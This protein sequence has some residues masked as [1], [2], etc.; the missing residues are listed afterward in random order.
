MSVNGERTVFW[1]MQIIMQ[2]L[3]QFF[4]RRMQ[5]PQERTGKFYWC[6]LGYFNPG[7]QSS[8]K[9]WG[10]FCPIR[11]QCTVMCVFEAKGNLSDDVLTVTQSKSSGTKLRVILT[12]YKVKKAGYFLRRSAWYTL[13]GREAAQTCIEKFK[14]FLFCHKIW[15]FFHLLLVLFL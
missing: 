9:Q 1:Q 12:L 7:R 11:D 3:F 2:R 5:N 13:K 4:N 8:R 6:Q 10:L 14:F 15:I